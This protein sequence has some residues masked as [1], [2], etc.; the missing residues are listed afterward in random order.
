LARPLAQESRRAYRAHFRSFYG[1]ALD[2]GRIEVNPADKLP[3]VRVKRGLPRPVSDD[4]LSTALAQADARMTSWLLLMNLAGRRCGEVAV[5]RPIDVI[6]ASDG[7]ASLYLRECKGGGTATMPAHPAI[8]HALDAVP[9]RDGEWWDCSAGL[10]Q[11]G[12]VGV[13]CTRPA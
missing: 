11:P 6:R 9:K 7:S 13:S 5:L 8:L 10:H 12:G 4:D 1:W 2:D 3:A